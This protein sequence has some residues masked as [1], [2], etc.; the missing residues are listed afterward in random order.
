MDGVRI[1]S[2]GDTSL[3][4]IKSE[5]NASRLSAIAPIES[6]KAQHKEQFDAD[7]RSL[8]NRMLEK[9][10][11]LARLERLLSAQ[12]ARLNICAVLWFAGIGADIFIVAKPS[13]TPYMRR[14]DMLP[15]II[16]VVILVI[17]T[18]IMGRFIYGLGK[19]EDTKKSMK[20]YPQEIARLE[21]QKVAIRQAY[22]RKMMELNQ[23]LSNVNNDLAFTNPDSTPNL[24]KDKIGSAQHVV[25]G[26]TNIGSTAQDYMKHAEQGNAKAQ[27]ML[28]KCY[29]EGIGVSRNLALGVEWYI[30]AA[31]QGYAQAQSALSS[32]YSSGAGIPKNPTLAYKWAKKAAEQGDASGKAQL[33]LCYYEGIGVAKNPALAFKWCLKAAEQGNEHGQCLVG[34]CYV[35]GVGVAMNH[36]LAVK[37]FNKAIA[38]GSTMGK[39]CLG[40][41]YWEGAGV[42]QDYKL[43]AELCK[44]AAE[45]DDATGQYILGVLYERGEGVAKNIPQAIK[46]YGRAA[47]Q[48]SEDAQKALE[49][50]S[51]DPNWFNKIQDIL[52]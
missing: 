32:C 17:G 36:K 38:Q 18:Q 2:A 20:P 22:E 31:E 28:G 42:R 13:E 44:E 12:R 46:W 3:N 7:T 9:Q 34:C 1:G 11:E 40:L 25:V 4:N 48:G 37:W 14:N 24:A 30:K 19:P 35:E 51:R 43:A 52:G 21:N 15:L 8:D 47:G 41:C 16:F 23:A 27:Y 33:G 29:T 26:K 5:L 50:L 6:P 10:G 49:R 39:S 45:E